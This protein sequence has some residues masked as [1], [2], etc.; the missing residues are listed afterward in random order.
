M[1]PYAAPK[2]EETAFNC[3][4]CG[5]YARQVW[6]IINYV[7]GITW[8]P[9]NDLQIVVCSHCTEYSL[10]HKKKMIYPLS[11]NA[12]LPNSDL[13]DEIKA[14]YEEARSIVGQSPRGAAALLRLA[15]Q[16]LCIFLGE[17]G[18]DINHDIANLVK[19]GLPTKIQKSLD[20]VRVVGNNAVHPG[21]IDLQDNPE[22]TEKL[23]GL[24]NLIT[25]VMITQPKHINELYNNTL[26][27]NQ[28]KAID[29]RDGK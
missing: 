29:K 18:K 8:Y 26:P 4:R 22:I 19:K 9:A 7:I 11:G 28:K 1:I 15:I 21:Q 27:E 14:D 6:A 2:Y 17:P 12:P 24:V 23:F 3:P 16:K 10:W 20:I 13:P 5:A 25:E